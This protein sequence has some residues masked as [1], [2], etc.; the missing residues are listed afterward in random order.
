MQKNKSSIPT[1]NPSVE[2]IAKR[3]NSTVMVAMLE[4]RHP[5]YKTWRDFLAIMESKLMRWR[6]LLETCFEDES[7]RNFFEKLN[8][9]RRAIL[10]QELELY[11]KDSIL[12]QRSITQ[13]TKIPKF[14]RLISG[15]LDLGI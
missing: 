10:R 14:K 9:T 12:R 5:I 13:T 4:F 6:W 8:P 3:E 15:C 7:F 11:P 1:G 2:E